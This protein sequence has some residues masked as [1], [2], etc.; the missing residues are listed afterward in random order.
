MAT[1]G[2]EARCNNKMKST[3]RFKYWRS[4]NN[5]QW[6]WHVIARNNRVVAIAGEGFNRRAGMFA[7]VRRLLDPAVLATAEQR[8]DN[9]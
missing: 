4:P 1:T 8:T 5:N 3:L 6:Y 2:T 7:S 9:E